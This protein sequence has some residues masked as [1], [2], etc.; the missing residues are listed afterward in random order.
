MN[1]LELLGY[2][3]QALRQDRN[4]GQD[5]MS[6]ALFRVLSEIH[7]NMVQHGYLSRRMFKYD[8]LDDPQ[9]AVPD[10]YSKYQTICVPETYLLFGWAFER[11]LTGDDRRERLEFVDLLAMLEKSQIVDVS[12][13]KRRGKTHVRVSLWD[14]GDFRAVCVE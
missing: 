9:F 10:R 4:L 14:E 6:P 7:K 13:V 8:D 3:I 1:K 11:W 2:L 12:Y 5:D